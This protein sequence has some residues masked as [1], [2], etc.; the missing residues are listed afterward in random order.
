MGGLNLSIGGKIWALVGLLVIGLGILVAQDLSTLRESMQD[1]RRQTL[2]RLVES[3][4]SIVEAQHARVAKG[5]VSEAEAKAT[6]LN[7][8]RGIR[9]GASDYFV[10]T[11]FQYETIMHPIRPD[12]V[13][14][15]MSQAKDTNGV[16]FVRELADQASK[17]GGGFVAY[18]FPKAKDQPP[19]PKLSYVKGFKPWGWAILTAVYMDDLDE[20]IRS[21]ATGMTVKAVLLVLAAAAMAVVMARSITKPLGV[22]VGR[23]G[24]LAAGDIASPVTGTERK[25]E[26]GQ[27]AR[28]M[29]I[30]RGN[31]IENRRLLDQ[32]EE[33]KRTA[34][35]DRNR[36]LRDMADGLESRVKAAVVAMT[37]VGERLNGASSAMAHTAEQTSEQT[38][39]VV[40][41]TEQTSSNVQTVASAAEELSASGSE[42]SRQVALTADIARSAASEAEQ[43]NAMVSTLAETAGRIGE[44][45]R[46]IDDIAS[47]TNLLALNATI[48]A[49]R[50]GEAGKGFAV[51]ANEVK[52]LANQTAKATQ[53]ITAQIGAVQGETEKAVVAIRRIAETINRVDEATASIAGAVEE[54]NAAI[55][56][57]SRSVQEAARG[58]HEVTRHIGDV[59]NGTRTSR[60][61]ADDVAT[62]AREMISQNGELNREI[63]T[64][65]SE[66]RSQAA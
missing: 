54:Q 60:Q 2:T 34:A 46:L 42:I 33:M 41:A 63:E 28:A 44:V 39:V 22:L 23:M 7:I 16:F 61:A 27:L 32:Q 13:G 47:Q 1:E 45:V 37:R 25:D 19:Q 15:D 6:A 58:T 52:T 21:K 36:T 51:V 4:I 14:K 40:A 30:F 66:I 64:F 20:E 59:S 56:E 48:E 57:I 5:E 11:T 35:V 24:A 29:E 10:I 50:A 49:A 3:A 12:L 65:L 18:H 8:L 17:Q 43:T 53:E 9:F 55:A 26:V 31:A 38:S 62:S